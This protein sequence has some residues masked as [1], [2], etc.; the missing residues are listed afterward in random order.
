MFSKLSRYRKLTDVVTTDPKGRELESRSL[1]LLPQV[2]GT[3]IHTVEEVDRLDHLAYKYYRQPRKWW[4]ICDANPEL[5]SPQGLLGK[6]PIVIT[7]FSLASDE[8]NPPWAEL[9]RRLSES[10]GVE[11]VQVVEEVKVVAGEQ[12]Q[13]YD[14][15]VIVRYNQMN[16]SAGELAD[17]ITVAGFVVTQQENIGRIGKRIIIPTD[18]VT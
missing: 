3:L 6:E 8:T 16:V 11:D 18:V 5:M 12:V 13:L 17:V 15:S 1:R 2:S 9:L 7:Q 14:R 4:R 10:V